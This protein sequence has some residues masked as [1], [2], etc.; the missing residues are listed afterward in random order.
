MTEMLESCG[1]LQYDNHQ[2]G[3]SKVINLSNL[4]DYLI[5]NK[6]IRFDEKMI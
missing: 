2:S 1:L 4:V 3:N 5:I 6:N